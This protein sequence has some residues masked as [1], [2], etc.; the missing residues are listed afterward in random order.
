MAG[1]TGAVAPGVV[2]AVVAPGV[3]GA[4]RALA[5]VV[6]PATVVVVV[7]GVVYVDGVADSEVNGICCSSLMC[8]FCGP[9]YLASNSARAFRR[10]TNSPGT[11]SSSAFA[12]STRSPLSPGLNNKPV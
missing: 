7:D 1:V 6:V 11:S 4:V 10:I 12:F 2:D 5:T 9:V 8:A 3:V